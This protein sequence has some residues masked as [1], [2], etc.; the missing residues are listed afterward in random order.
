M[1]LL[2][3]D[4]SIVSPGV[5]LFRDGMLVVSAHF[6]VKADKTACAARRCVKAIDAILA[7][8]TRDFDVHTL[9]FEYPQIY[10]HDTPA[11]ANAVIYMAGV[12]MGLTYALPA[13]T[14]VLSY[15]PR[16][17]WGQLP[18]SKTGSY[19]KSA[20]GA[21]VWSRL[22]VNERAVAGDQH[23]QGDAIGIGLFHLGRF[24]VQHAPFTS[25]RD[26]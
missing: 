10:A 9:V 23:D 14:D 3:L 16:E 8:V 22:D 17:I 18:K 2:A 13:L 12:G 11:T 26:H 25:T 1:N 7:W 21:R 15:V 4:P 19:W 5:A 20:R 6:K 24:G